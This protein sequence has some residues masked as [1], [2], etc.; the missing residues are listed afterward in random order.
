VWIGGHTERALAR[1]ATLGD[2]WHAAFPSVEKM[3]DGLG[4]LREACRRVGRDPATLTVSARVGLPARRSSA[5]V[6]T[7][8]RALGD[9]G[10]A[11][12]I[13]ETGGRDVAQ[14]TATCERFAAEVRP[15]L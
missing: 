10:V 1:V 12:V 3:Q 4:R 13:L 9:L 11:H 8:V 5:D 15:Q 2:G 7:E 14:M 6:L